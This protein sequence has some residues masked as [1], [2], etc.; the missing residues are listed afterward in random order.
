MLVSILLFEMLHYALIFNIARKSS[1]A[2]F[3]FFRANQH[4]LVA[5]YYTIVNVVEQLHRMQFHCVAF[6]KALHQFI[7]CRGNNYKLHGLNYQRNNHTIQ[8]R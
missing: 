1:R 7:V 3:E 5:F 8:R 6:L 4:N 2:P